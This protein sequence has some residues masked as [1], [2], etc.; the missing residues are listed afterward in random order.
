MFNICILEDDLQYRKHICNLIQT[1]LH[2]DKLQARIWV[3]TDAPEDIIR[4]LDAGVALNIFFLDIYIHGTP[5]GFELAK[6]I[7]EKVEDAHIIFI[8]EKIDFVFHSFRVK[9][10]DFITKPANHQSIRR[11]FKELCMTFRKKHKQRKE[12]DIDNEGL[13]LQSSPSEP[14]LTLKS[15][16]SILYLSLEKLV[17]VEQQRN[18][19]MYHLDNECVMTYETMESIEKNLEKYAAF[20]RIHRSFIVN[21]GRIEK[22]NFSKR[23]VL[24]DTGAVCPVGIRY[25]QFV[26]NL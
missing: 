20:V 21:R 3:D 22:I 17:Y 19:A 12:K 9:A 23:E 24:M 1:V 14:R 11:V 7:H 6:L 10:F 18:K 4:L 26:K 16:T 15:G 8:S 2:E 13:P 5:K 25:K